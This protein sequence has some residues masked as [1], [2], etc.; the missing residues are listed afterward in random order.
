MQAPMEGMQDLPEAQK[1][2]LLQRIEEM[3]VRD[4]CEKL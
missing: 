2:A 1:Q 3:Q 4:R